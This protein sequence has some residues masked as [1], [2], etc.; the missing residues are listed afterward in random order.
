MLQ[1]AYCI[2][3]VVTEEHQYRL[4]SVRSKVECVVQCRLDERCLSIVYNH[5]K[6]KCHLAN[7]RALENCT[8]MEPMSPAKGQAIIF[9]QE[10]PYCRRGEMLGSVGKCVCAPGFA[11]SPCKR[12]FHDCSDVYHYGD[13]HN[14]EVHNV[15][16]LSS[17]ASFQV[18][19]RQITNTRTYIMQRKKKKNR[20]NFNRPWADYRNGFG[21]LNSD[22]WLGL[23]KVHILTAVERSY[24]LRVNLKLFNNSIVALEYEDF[25]I[26]NEKS[27]YR[28]TFNSAV[29]NDTQDCLLPLFNASFSTFDKDQ[30][31]NDD[32]NCA[33]SRKGGFWF[34]GENCSTCNPNGVIYGKDDGTLRGITDEAFWSSLG[35]AAPFKL[36]MYLVSEEF[37]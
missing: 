11:G 26:S 5:R 32:V 18:L 16:P 17:P 22:F 23:E 12:Y 1:A 2:D 20:Q 21:D 6:Q 13:W 19:C 8:N 15:K 36:Y 7:A 4:L 27:G 25:K 28:I 29:V 37:F 14:N 35:D 34:R 9:Y 10:A 30:D 3:K 31:Q 24:R 33:E